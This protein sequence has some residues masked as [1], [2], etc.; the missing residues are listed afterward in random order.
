[1]LKL[2]VEKDVERLEG[3][4]EHSLDPTD[5][6]HLWT[7]RVMLLQVPGKEEFYKQCCS[8]AEDKSDHFIHPTRLYQVCAFLILNVW[9]CMLS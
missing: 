3:T 1:M 8:L 4:D 2:F 5:A 9:S 7:A 6:S